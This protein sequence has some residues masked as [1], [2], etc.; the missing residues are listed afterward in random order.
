[1][2]GVKEDPGISLTIN[3]RYFSLEQVNSNEGTEWKIWEQS[4]DYNANG[5]LAFRAAEAARRQGEEVFCKFHYALYEA[6]HKKYRNIAD[7]SRVTEVA[8]SAGLDMFR[9]KKDIRDARILD[10]LAEDHTYAAG[11]LK[12]FGTPTL[13]FP[14]NQAVYLK[15]TSVPSNEESLL[16]FTEIRNIAEKRR[17]ILEIK[18][19]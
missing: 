4:D 3:W 2:Q 17:I 9:F 6:R 13:V 15:M 5:L 18:R 7:I 8:E 16:I 12:I 11:T 14:E 19:P 10:T 1:M